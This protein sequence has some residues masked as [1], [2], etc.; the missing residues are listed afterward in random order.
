MRESRDRSERH[1][2]T[3]EQVTG[4]KI[5][6]KGERDTALKSIKYRCHYDKKKLALKLPQQATGQ[7]IFDPTCDI[8]TK[9]WR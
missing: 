5:G 9:G 7:L 6:R 2:R 8:L 3:M 1:I 4:E